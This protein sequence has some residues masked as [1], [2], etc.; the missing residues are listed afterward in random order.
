MASNQTQQRR[1]TYSKLSSQIALL[2]NIQVRGLLDNTQTQNGQTQN[3]W[4]K[5][6]TLEIESSK[7]FLKRIPITDLEYANQFSTRNLYDLPMYYHYG[8]GSAGFNVFR[9]L[10]THLKTTNWVLAGAAASFPL[11]YGYRILPTVGERVAI[12]Q[13]AHQKYVDYWGGNPNISRYVTDRANANHELV[14]FLEYIPDTVGEWLPENP[15]K[16]GRLLEDMREALA[17]LRKNGILHLDAHFHNIVTDGEQFYLTDF[18][19]AL[20]REFEMNAE[21]TD[22]HNRH[23]DYDAAQ[24]LTG[25]A[26]H[27]LRVWRNGI[28]DTERNRL[29]EAYGITE[30]MEQSELLPLLT[31]HRAA[32]QADL[33]LSLDQDSRARLAEYLPMLTLMNSFYSELRGNPQKDTPF[34]PLTVQRLLQEMNFLRI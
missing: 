11:M 13:E 1:E 2:S 4:G 34:D 14:I 19:L 24:F 9:E 10:V 3:G 23:T 29:S 21:E 7:V 12:D 33:R 32:I 31:K 17:A 8:I 18:G 20:D 28:T 5:T 15:S 27:H 30:D 25:L 26:F 22:F 6:Q 16:A